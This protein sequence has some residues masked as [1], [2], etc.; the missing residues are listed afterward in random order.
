M[1]NR[2]EEN[3][4]NDTDEYVWARANRDYGRRYDINENNIGGVKIKDTMKEYTRHYIKNSNGE[5][6][7]GEEEEEEEEEEDDDDDD[8][9][10]DVGEIIPH[11]LI[12]FIGK[13]KKYLNTIRKN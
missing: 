6:D 8:D 9:D 1:E 13:M 3:E 11:C 2:I 4:L 10:D 12:T 7:D 5:D